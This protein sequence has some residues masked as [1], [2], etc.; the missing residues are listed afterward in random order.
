MRTIIDRGGRFRRIRIRKYLSSGAFLVVFFTFFA[1]ALRVAFLNFDTLSN[2]TLAGALNEALRFAFFVGPVVVYLRYVERTPTLTF[3][4]I[5]RPHANST[6]VLPLLERSS[7]ASTCC[8]TGPS[9]TVRLPAP[10]WR[11]YCSRCSPRPRWPRKS[12]F[13]ASS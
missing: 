8:W 3:L 5:K 10:S 6:W 13:G 7:C 9:G 4:K 1:W 12:I 11:R 2:L